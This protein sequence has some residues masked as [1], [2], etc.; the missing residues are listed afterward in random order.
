MIAAEFQDDLWIPV[1]ENKINP[2]ARDEAY[3]P[4]KSLKAF[5]ERIQGRLTQIKTDANVSS[6]HPEVRKLSGLFACTKDDGKTAWMVNVDA[7]NHIGGLQQSQ[8]YMFRVREH[9]IE[10]FNNENEQRR[11]AVVSAIQTAKSH[12]NRFLKQTKTVKSRGDQICSWENK[13][14]YVEDVAGNK[15]RILVKGMVRAKQGF[16]FEL[17]QHRFLPA[18]IEEHI[19][20]DSSNWG[21][22]N[23]SS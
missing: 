15:I 23:F 5:C 1:F 19:W 16:F 22:C 11:L 3:A 14:G 7:I 8:G 9:G 21:S 2:F 10:T 13:F 6:Y 20:D 18:K 17:T 12:R 4:I